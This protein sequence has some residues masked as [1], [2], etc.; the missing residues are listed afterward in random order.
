MVRLPHKENEDV[1]DDHVQ[2][3]EIKP[4]TDGR[5]CEF[6]TGSN[7][8]GRWRLVCP[9]CTDAQCARYGF[10]VGSVCAEDSE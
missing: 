9:N 8:I 4:R 2:N 6:D 7:R 10:H 3:A 5:P 1:E